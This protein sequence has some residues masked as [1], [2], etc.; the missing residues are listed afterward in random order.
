MGTKHLEAWHF[1]KM[2]GRINYNAYSVDYVD[3]TYA[4]IK[5]GDVVDSPICLRKP[6]GDTYVV[7]GVLHFKPKDTL[8]IDPDALNMHLCSQ[9]S[10]RLEKAERI[11]SE[12][13]EYVTRLDHM[14]EEV[15][16]CERELAR[17][18]QD[19]DMKI[20]QMD[21]LY[22]IVDD[23]NQMITDKQSILEEVQTKYTNCEH[24]L[25]NS[26]QRLQWLDH[27]WERWGQ[28]VTYI[29]HQMEQMRYLSCAPDEKIHAFIER[30]E[31][32]HDLWS[33]LPSRFNNEDSPY[34]IIRDS[35]QMLAVA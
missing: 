20:S 10:I 11:R 12:Y 16:S 7:E 8:E 13:L 26:I 19:I 3:N 17:C 21:R 6:L 29:R 4:A 9:T 35:L 27:F 1:D 5:S 23:I 30:A 28:Y 25:S 31:M 22:E 18:R 24:M 14:R 33:G 32:Y 34:D 2:Y 15:Y